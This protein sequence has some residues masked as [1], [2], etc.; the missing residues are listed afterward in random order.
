MA[1]TLATLPMSVIW[2]EPPA[3]RKSYVKMMPPEQWGFPTCF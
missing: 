2:L 1:I 3:K